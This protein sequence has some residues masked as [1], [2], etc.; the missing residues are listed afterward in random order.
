MREKNATLSIEEIAT[1]LFDGERL[2]HFLE[3]YD[4]LNRNKLGKRKTGRK[5]SSFSWAITYKKQR[6]GGFSFHGNSW[7]IVF[8]NLFP[9]KEW[10]ARCEEYLTAELKEVILA[11]IDTT[12]NCCVKGICNSV[13]NP[14][15]LGER[16]NGRVCACGPIKF[17]DPDDKTLKYAKELALIGKKII[18]EW[19]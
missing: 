3:F 13:E 16:F 17:I 11:N 14:I 10:F 12:S 7:S 5:A 2:N 19:R 18:A 4:F 1:G 15:I 9:A 8:F 6:I